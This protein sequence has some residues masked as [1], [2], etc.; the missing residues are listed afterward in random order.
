MSILRCS[1]LEARNLSRALG[2]WPYVLVVSWPLLVKLQE[3]DFFFEAGVPF[4]WASL[5]SL[6]M[7]GFGMLPLCLRFCQVEDRNWVER[8]GRG[9]GALVLV[10]WLAVVGLGTQLALAA[11]AVSY[12]V[13]RIYT[14]SGGGWGR[15][16]DTAES[17][18]GFLLLTASLSPILLRVRVRTPTL[19]FGW[20]LFLAVAAQW[21]GPVISTGLTSSEISAAEYGS[22]RILSVV[23]TVCV[24]I[25]GL[26]F[27]LAHSKH[28][29]RS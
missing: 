28:R 22:P 6:L 1:L 16:L 20:L 4:Y 18:L 29:L 11:L 2:I 19:V 21:F 15:C 13:D 14:G 24:T 12:T 23:S 7:L 25:G 8:L 17:S 5:E 3:P 10:P 9:P 27:S 26:A